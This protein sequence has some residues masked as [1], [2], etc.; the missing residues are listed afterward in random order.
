MDER[1]LPAI[2]L[3][4]LYH[5]RW[6]RELVFGEIKMQMVFTT[7]AL[8]SNLPKSVQQEIWLVLLTI[9]LARSQMVQ[10]TFQNKLSPPRISFKYSISPSPDWRFSL[11][12]RQRQ[13]QG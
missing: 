12:N 4:Q 11:P 6:E 2:E 9:N 1:P 5:Q 3:A 8:R 10:V 13:K 7:E